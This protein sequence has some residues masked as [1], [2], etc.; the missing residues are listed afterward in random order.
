MRFV[1]IASFLATL[2]YSSLAGS[3]PVQGLCKDA[4]AFHE[5]KLREHKLRIEPSLTS[6]IEI[7]VEL[8][9]LPNVSKINDLRLQIRRAH[10]FQNAASFEGQGCRTIVYDP[11]WAAGD[12]AEFYLVLGH[13]AGHHFCGHTVGNVRGNR[14]QTELEADQFGGAAIKQYEIYHGQKLFS[15]VYAAAQAKYPEQGSFLYPPRA[16]RL[17]ALRRGYEQGSPCGGLTRA[18]PGYSPP[19]RTMGDKPCRPIQTGPTSWSCER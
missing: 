16:L 4:F 14:L 13:E 6:D 5:E 18:I 12:T 3:Q 9:G 8:I 15:R 2:F 7:L 10:G 19:A 11:E 1:V 17:E